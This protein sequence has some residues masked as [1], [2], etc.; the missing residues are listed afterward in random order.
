VSVLLGN[1]DAT[2][3]SQTTLAT[4]QAPRGITVADLNG[5][6]RPDLVVANRL[7]TASVLLGNGNGTFAPQ[8]TLPV[9]NFA[10]SVAVA[11]LNGDGKPDLVTANHVDQNV[12]LL[13][14]NGDGTFQNQVTLA[15]GVL[16]ASV[17]IA[18]VNG[19]GYPDLVVANYSDSTTS[20]LLGNGNGTFQ[21]QVTL[22]TGSGS[23]F[24]ST[25][26]L[27]AD[28]R[29]DLITAN[30]G[31]HTAGVLLNN[32][33]GDFAGQLYTID[34]TP[35][36][37]QSI[38]RTT[39]AGPST[40]GSATFTVTFT[41]PVTG[42]DLTDFVVP[43]SGVTYSSFFVAGSGSV[44]TVTFV[45]VSGNGTLGLN[46]VN[47]GSIA[48]LV[49]NPLSAGFTGQVY[50]VDQTPPVV[51]SISRTTPA[52]PTAGAG[53]VT[54][55]V[56]FSEPVTG[57]DPADFALALS[58]V[59]AT[60]PVT[61]SGTGSV[62][63]VTINGIAGNGTLG[64]NLVNDGTIRDLAIN[65]LVG[66]F[67][68]QVYSILPSE[69]GVVAGRHIFYNQSVWDGNSA[70]ISA[71]NDNAAIAPG[72]VPHLPGGGVAVAANITSFSRGINGIMVDLSAG[73][74]THTGITAADFVFKVGNNNSPN[75][76]AAAPVPSAISVIPGGGVGGSDRVEITWASGVVKNQWLEVQVLPTVNTGLATTD[77]HFW[78]NKIGDSASTSPATT[79]ETTTTDAA[80]V[81][82]NI[83]AGKPITDLRDY[84]RDGAVTT[85]DAAI[86][87][88]NIGNIVRLNIGG[89]GPFAPEAGPMSASGSLVITNETVKFPGRTS[90]SALAS[91]LATFERFRD[92]ASPALT[93]RELANARSESDRFG[94]LNRHREH[95]SVADR[96]RALEIYHE[97]SHDLNLDDELL[98]SLLDVVSAGSARIGIVPLRQF[99]R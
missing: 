52:G 12:S 77:V 26:D 43:V 28:G 66:G 35:P 81:F 24:V 55:T 93:I 25:A 91:A 44:Y 39:P 54:Y 73:V 56:T 70:A 78:G 40:N 27:N 9:G 98:D 6:G 22:P 45:G 29:L 16:P 92:D 8:T 97:Q 86:V 72:K 42:V 33:V 71:V 20:V 18:D 30:Y 68:G 88:A 36:V 49:T 67:T 60:T 46:V 57:V 74:V 69:P 38:N 61:V 94:A 84:N 32:A 10:Y 95:V 50:T 1:G 4:G 75:T 13:L 53:S 59:V 34:Q 99:D 65:L 15:T 41:E 90:E 80:Q 37:V 5:D 14:G 48:D 62:Y 96:A 11:D 51:Q 17:A 63:T 76:W 47:N 85:T 87:F 64:L 58:F 89:V 2:F 21:N 23:I 7:G 3:Q 82:G 31:N 19:D 79:F 83:G